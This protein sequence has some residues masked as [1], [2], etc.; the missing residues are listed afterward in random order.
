MCG[1]I[2]IC[3]RYRTIDMGFAVLMSFSQSRFNILPQASSHRV[4]Y[5]F[6]DFIA[7]LENLSA[8]CSWKPMF[9]ECSCLVIEVF[10]E[11]C[12]FVQD[13]LVNAIVTLNTSVLPVM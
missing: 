10:V 6:P 11:R 4:L 13:F 5:F 2:N 9:S 3:K 8:C 1:F 7:V 12:L